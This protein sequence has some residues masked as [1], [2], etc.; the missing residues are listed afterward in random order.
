MEYPLTVI[1]KGD[2]E[3][4]IP[5][6]KEMYSLKE[7]CDGKEFS[8]KD[9]C[10]EIVYPIEYEMP[11]GSVIQGK[12]EDE[13]NANMKSWYKMHPDSKEKPNLVYPVDVL[14]KDESTKTI[15]N[16]DEMIKLKKDC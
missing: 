5:S 14:L 12:N 1:F 7:Y 15:N 13:A 16:E 2:L 8:K 4:T 6:E 3:K 9:D 10:F 11:D